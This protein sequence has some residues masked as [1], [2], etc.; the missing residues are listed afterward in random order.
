MTSFSFVIPTYNHYNLLHQSL[1]DIYQKC[2]PVD[3]VI[4]VDDCSD[5]ED[6]RNGLKWWKEQG[7]LPIRHL[8]LP[9]NVG[10]LRASNAGLKRAQGD[11]VCLLSNDVRIY[12]DIV[13]EIRK[14]LSSR[15]GGTLVGGR[16]L[17]F[18][19]G[20]NTFNDRVFPYLE[21]WLLATTKDAWDELFYLDTQYAPCDME[22]VDLSTK[23]LNLGY[24]LEALPFDMTHHLGGQSIGFNPER[25][26]ITI[27]NKE[28]FRQKWIVKNS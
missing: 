27:A 3:E 18:D 28:R 21:G 8:R 10:F 16:L 22:D 5:A 25:E 17:D 23:A 2:Y 26:K 20:W 7:M 14:V 13:S 9:E 4:V 12:R 11:I 1:F 24:K 6:Y 15:T 19:T